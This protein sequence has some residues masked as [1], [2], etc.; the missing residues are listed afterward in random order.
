MIIIGDVHHTDIRIRQESERKEEERL[1]LSVG[2]V[3][4]AVLS[5][6]T[7]TCAWGW[8][9]SANH[10]SWGQEGPCIKYAQDEVEGKDKD[11]GGKEGFSSRYEHE[12]VEDEDADKVR[13][14]KKKRRGP[15]GDEGCKRR[16][17]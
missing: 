3:G 7:P 6:A 1:D 16:S 12:E 11:R 8:S 15:R 9:W 10:G 17:E 2:S 14:K 13:T 5:N 4:A